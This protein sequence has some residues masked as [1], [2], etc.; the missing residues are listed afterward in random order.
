MRMDGRGIGI[1]LGVLLIA[2]ALQPVALAQDNL[3]DGAPFNGYTGVKFD[4]TK[5]RL[6]LPG[7]QQPAPGRP[8]QQEVQD[9]AGRLRRRARRHAGA[10]RPSSASSP[11]ST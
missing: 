10:T 3:R 5:L 11:T 2:T 6:R 8:G 1:A 9:G 4:T 7:R